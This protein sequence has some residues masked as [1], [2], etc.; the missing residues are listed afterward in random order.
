MPDPETRDPED[1]W[2]QDPSGSHLFRWW[3][4]SWSDHVSDGTR[5]ERS[6]LP[7]KSGPIRFLIPL[8]FVPAGA[9]LLLLALMIYGDP[10]PVSRFGVAREGPDL[11]VVNAVCPG[12]RLLSVELSRGV[13]E[14]GD[15]SEIL[16]QI[17][18]STPL[19]EKFS[20]GDAGPNV[21]SSTPFLAE[22]R[23]DDILALRVVT[24]DLDS[25]YALDFRP[26]E[27]P[28]TGVLSFDSVYADYAGFAES[29]LE[30]TPCGDA[31]GPELSRSVKMMAFGTFVIAGVG[32]LVLV[33]TRRARRRHS[34]SDTWDPPSTRR[35]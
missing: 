2:Y 7:Y 8:M 1:G 17:F 4:R 15:R 12:E 10:F 34:P 28:D 32:V 25:S 26:R 19:R 16:W 3:A 33:R 14:G 5:V 29:V 31:R 35:R 24:T 30:Q 21:V 6:L 23:P 13:P 18:D 9:T 20:F 11:V 27:I 22:L